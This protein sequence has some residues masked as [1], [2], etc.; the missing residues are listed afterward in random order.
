MTWKKDKEGSFFREAEEEEEVHGY[1]R[2]TGVV[3]RFQRIPYTNEEMHSTITPDEY[4]SLIQASYADNN[5]AERIG[6]DIH[7]TLDKELSNE[8]HKVFSDDM[9]SD[10]IIAYTGTR[11]NED[12]ITDGALAFGVLPLTRRFKDS[13]NVI[14][15]IKFKY[16]KSPIM[17]IGDSLGGSLA[18]SV[19][20][21][22]DRVITHNKGTS[23]FDVGKKIRDNQID[24]RHKNDWI[25]TLSRF[26]T[27]GQD[28][29]TIDDG[30][31]DF[32][33]SHD[34][35]NVKGLKGKRNRL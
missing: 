14:D 10:I 29:I 16:K 6:Q 21:K 20:D 3:P 23:I 33:E 30:K 9:D 11:K 17:A 4:E 13:R 15:D 1:L 26:E 34:Y 18:E 5:E 31:T 32:F 19:G 12:Y 28:K 24:I 2:G 22:V 25:S 8:N 35:R 27:G 7:Y